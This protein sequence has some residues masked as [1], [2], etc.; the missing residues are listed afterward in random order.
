M[1]LMASLSAFIM[2]IS[3]DG[4]PFRHFGF[5]TGNSTLQVDC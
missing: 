4:N 1:D 3:L 2:V 5:I